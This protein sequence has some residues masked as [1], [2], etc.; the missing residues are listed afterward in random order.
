MTP[1]SEP[2]AAD[3]IDAD[4]LCARCGYNLRTLPPESVCPECAHPVRESRRP[5]RLQHADVK[6]LR[7]VRWGVWLAMVA[8][9]ATRVAQ[10]A[11]E[12]CL[13]G[14]L[15]IMAI[16][17]VTQGEP[18]IMHRTH[19]G[20]RW[21]ARLMIS[22]ACIVMAAPVQLLF[23]LGTTMVAFAGA[24]IVLSAGG[25]MA[26]ILWLRTL[27]LRAEATWT[28]HLAAFGVASHALASAA[29]IELVPYVLPPGNPIANAIGAI[30]HEPNVSRTLRLNG[31]FLIPLNL[32]ILF[33]VRGLLSAA[34]GLT[35]ARQRRMA[36]E[37]S[38]S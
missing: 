4:L 14:L 7:T 21:A 34:I 22:T 33:R 20:K 9:L 12:R 8:Y 27:C 15:S 16:I 6:W 1:D 18:G 17:L 31:M 3:I 25:W 37:A 26:L 2:G 19:A 10:S 24:S 38:Q 30:A 23:G 35:E 36:E 32:A 5:R 29:I 13:A 11:V 28:A